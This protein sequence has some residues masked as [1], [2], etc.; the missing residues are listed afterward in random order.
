MVSAP[1]DKPG[2]N[3]AGRLHGDRSG[4]DAVAAEAARSD[5]RRTSVGSIAVQAESAGAGLGEAAVA[6]VSGRSPG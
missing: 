5:E 1:T 6:A 2:E 4:D 3:A